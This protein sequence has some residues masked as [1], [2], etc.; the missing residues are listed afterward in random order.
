MKPN[1]QLHKNMNL[2]DRNNEDVVIQFT[3]LSDVN[4]LIS[5]LHLV[6]GF[7]ENNPSY[8]VSS[9]E[10]LPVI[11]HAVNDKGEVYS[12]GARLTA[13]TE[14]RKGCHNCAFGSWPCQKGCIDVYS[15]WE[16]N[17]ELKS[18]GIV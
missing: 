2:D 1:I 5:Y 16:P 9:D 13:K 4:N 11:M 17:E 15:Q 14:V 7:L 12:I 3:N 6:K 10:V 8:T 18:R